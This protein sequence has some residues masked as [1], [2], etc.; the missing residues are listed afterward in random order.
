[1]AT[2]S[3]QSRKALAIAKTP[4]Q[5]KQQVVDA[6]VKSWIAKMEWNNII[7]NG[8]VIGSTSDYNWSDAANVYNENTK[9]FSTGTPKVTEW[10]VEVAT[11]P[12]TP[13]ATD[14]TQANQWV[15]SWGATQQWSATPMS[16]PQESN[17]QETLNNNQNVVSGQV[18]GMNVT[19]TKQQ[20]LDKA[21]QSGQA[22]VDQNWNVTMKDGKSAGNIS[23]ID[24]TESAIWVTQP[25]SNDVIKQQQAQNQSSQQQ[26]QQKINNINPD[27]SL[28][29]S[30]SPDS[31]FWNNFGQSAVESENQLPGYLNARNKVIASDVML[32]N[33]DM[34]YMSDTMRKDAILK[35]IIDRQEM[36][37]DENIKDWYAKTVD[38]INNLI[39]RELPSYKSDDYFKMMVN[40]EKIPVIATKQNPELKAGRL[41]YNDMQKYAS[42]DSNGLLDAVTKWDLNRGS[43]TWNDLINKGLGDT[44]EKV[45]SMYNMQLASNITNYVS[46]EASSYN[47]DKNLASQG[48]MKFNFGTDIEWQI[49]TKLM[50]LMTEDKIPTLASALLENEEVQ[51]ARKASKATETEI[52]NLSDKIT[53]FSD[54]IKAKIMETGGGSDEDPFIDSYIAERTKPFIKQMTALNS[55]YRNEIALLG[56]LSENARTEFEV[57]EFNKQAEIQWYQFVLS[58]L[59]KQKA[60]KT[61]A[62]AA[63]L[64]QSNWE[65]SFAQQGSQFNQSMAMQQ[66]QFEATQANVA[67]TQSNREK[68]FNAANPVA[69]WTPTGKVVD[70]TF[71]G[72]TFKADSWMAQALSNVEAALNAAGIWWDTWASNWPRSKEE[73]AAL[74]KAGKSRTMNSNHNKWLAVDM[75]TNDGMSSA[76]WKPTPEMIKIMNDNW[77]FQDPKLIKLW[78]SGHF[79]YKWVQWSWNISAEQW[80]AYNKLLNTKVI[81][82]ASKLSDSERENMV[83]SMKQAIYEWD[84]DYAN[85]ILRWVMLNDKRVWDS[86]YDNEQL[87]S[88]LW[89][90]RTTLEEFSKSWNTNVLRSMAEKAANYLGTTTDEQLAK[91]NNQLWVLVAD[92]IRSISGTAASDREVS[93]LVNNL[94]NIKNVKS[95]NLSLLDNL[96]TIAN[97]KMKTNIELFLGNYKSMAS[98]LFPEV[99]TSDSQNMSDNTIVNSSPINNVY[100]SPYWRW[101]KQ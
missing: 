74:V 25:G 64:A 79:D 84:S 99:Y 27:T 86:I 11:D 8:K 37:I 57:K 51:M 53:E 100:S 38:N 69:P 23:W 36:G 2:T 55:K 1:M 33:T 31:P 72:K 83:A 22:T 13:A 4:N 30:N 85:E 98:T 93:R 62:D 67:Q 5:S 95:F 59:D 75:Y 49:S 47:K 68:T 12:N 48:S 60:D 56:D 28:W 9:K 101:N 26:D 88:W 58:R 29:L 20:A 73:Q 17:K 78:D 92:Y 96:E 19:Q 50:S 16:G 10:T 14:Q 71:G 7:V 80:N 63:A 90:V 15:Q 52:N 46:W 82:G 76:L 61:A 18:G 44:L 34:K 35:N 41:R 40:G 94:P 54:D 81:A 39:T 43:Q 89:L 45:Y 3:S 24:M 91:A 6:F 66:K 77:F 65:K 42:M 87:K 70:T 32:S 97:T 21:I